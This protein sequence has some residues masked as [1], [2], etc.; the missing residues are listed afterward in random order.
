MLPASN[1]HLDN[2]VS[3]MQHFKRLYATLSNVQDNLDSA[4]PQLLI[5]SHLDNQVLQMLNVVSMRDT[6]SNVQDSLDSAS[7]Q[8]L[9]YSHLDNQVS[10]MQHFTNTCMLHVPTSRTT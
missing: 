9:I 10:Q 1:S 6:I 5:S 3:Q 7:P 8:L 4:P 2:Q